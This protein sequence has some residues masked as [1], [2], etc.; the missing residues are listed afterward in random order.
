MKIFH[1]AFW[2]SFVVVLS[3]QITVSQSTF[4][5][6]S[7]EMSSDYSQ[8]PKHRRE[9][10]DQAPWPVT[11]RRAETMDLDQLTDAISKHDPNFQDIWIAANMGSN[12]IDLFEFRPVVHDPRVGRMVR[13]LREMEPQAASDRCSL[14]FKQKLAEMRHEK[15]FEKIVNDGGH[16]LGMQ[17]GITAAA[18]LCSQFCCKEEFDE[19]MVEWMTWQRSH[20]HY[21]KDSADGH[22]RETYNR[23]ERRTGQ[24]PAAVLNLYYLALLNAGMP[25][26]EIK[27]RFEEILAK[28]E[29]PLPTMR[30]YGMRDRQGTLKV[31]PVIIHIKGKICHHHSKRSIQLQIIQEVRE[32]LI[33]PSLIERA[34]NKIVDHAVQET[35]S[36]IKSWLELL[37][38]QKGKGSSINKVRKF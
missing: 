38:Q 30:E 6:E 29:T 2:F 16:G 24:N 21:W 18:F 36:Y 9:P 25:E 35:N 19:C 12:P 11:A 28:H 15:P 13:L 8:P 23:F 20:Y 3:A 10:P 33:P 34:V 7:S 22:N 31:L 17:H 4:Q 14:I 5:T 1:T 26:E 27:N 32:V 37:E